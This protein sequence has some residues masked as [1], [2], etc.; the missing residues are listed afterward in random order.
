MNTVRFGLM[1]KQMG[2][3]GKN[4]QI[5]LEKL[6]MYDWYHCSNTSHLTAGNNGCYSF[7]IGIWKFVFLSS[8]LLL[9]STNQF[10]EICKFA[11]N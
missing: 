11:S 5:D 1:K 8:T 6:L 3:R 9:I 7:V 4:T 2:G 10:A